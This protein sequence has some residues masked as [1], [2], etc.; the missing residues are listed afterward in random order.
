MVALILTW[1]PWEQVSERIAHTAVATLN[2]IHGDLRS[3][4]FSFQEESYRK[5]VES[6]HEL[7]AGSQ[8]V[9][10]FFIEFERAIKEVR[11][12]SGLKGK[13]ACEACCEIFARMGDL[14]ITFHRLLTYRAD[15]DSEYYGSL[16][17]MF[18]SKRAMI[19]LSVDQRSVRIVQGILDQLEGQKP[20]ALASL[21]NMG[22]RLTALGR[23]VAIGTDE[24]PTKTQS[25]LLEC[26]RKLIGGSF[27]SAYRQTK[28]LITIMLLN[29][30]WQKCKIAKDDLQNI[31]SSLE[32]PMLEDVHFEKE[33][34]VE[35]TVAL[36][37]GINIVRTPNFRGLSIPVVNEVSDRDDFGNLD[38][39]DWAG[40]KTFTP[41]SVAALRWVSRC[42]LIGKQFPRIA[43]QAADAAADILLLY[44]HTVVETIRSRPGSNLADE[45]TLD[46][47]LVGD[48]K[49]LLAQLRN[50]YKKLEDS[51][52]DPREVL[53]G[54]FSSKASR[55]VGPQTSL[56]NLCVAIES[57]WT[58]SMVATPICAG[59][60][61]GVT[62]GH[63]KSQ[64]LRLLQSAI[65]MADPVRRASYRLLAMDLCGGTEMI[66]KIAS[67]AYNLSSPPSTANASPCILQRMHHLRGAASGVV[68]PPASSEN[69]WPLICRSLFTIVVRGFSRVPEVSSYGVGRMLVDVA[70]VEM[71][72]EEFSGLRP[73][74]GAARARAYVSAFH[75]STEEDLVAWIITEG[76]SFQFRDMEISA[77]AYLG[78]VG[79]RC[80]ADARAALVSRVRARFSEAKAS[81]TP[82]RQKSKEDLGKEE[83]REDIRQ[84]EPKDIGNEAKE[85]RGNEA[86]EEM[87]KEPK[88]EMESEPKEEME[89]EPKEEMENEAKEEMK[90]EAKEEMGNEPKEEMGKEPTGDV[91]NESKE[92]FVALGESTL[93]EHPD[94]AANP[95]TAQEGTIN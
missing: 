42:V 13:A 34:R 86:K 28:E 89:N 12:P 11:I 62:S 94:S 7:N 81:Y 92:N 47:Y 25:S 58:L 83:A 79:R 35:A 27:K 45:V 9:D 75:F 15:A 36:I 3:M 20:E 50:R 91:G 52:W 53:S 22:R 49:M 64:V 95:C 90:N 73:V 82:M 33:D 40:S 51:S 6:Y 41:S 63:A 84:E 16:R 46:I 72:L 37:E 80:T 48:E 1:K 10:R 4:C 93:A 30:T 76:L 55:E 74:P 70:T 43:V 5:M 68:L 60:E 32:N 23:G 39:I 71:G 69:I 77:L 88:E 54:V 78:E 57:L 87:R 38:D 2:M 85:E 56:S 18:G 29:E 44:A 21:M 26:L 31:R 65:D 61:D 19:W 67:S 14:L 8:L 24:S 17:R 59:L 66:N